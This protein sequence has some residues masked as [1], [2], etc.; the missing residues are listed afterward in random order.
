M[1]LMSERVKTGNRRTGG[2]EMEYIELAETENYE[3]IFRGHA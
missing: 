3:R 1:A 2:S